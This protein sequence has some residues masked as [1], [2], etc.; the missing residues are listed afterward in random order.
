LAAFHDFLDELGIPRE[1]QLVR[2]IALEG[3][4]PE[5]VS[6]ARESLVPEITVTADGVYWHPVTATDERF[7]VTRI[8][9]PL[10]PALDTISRLFAEQWARTAEA[11]ALFP[12]A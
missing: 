2:P 7:L 8:I 3:A 4:A 1:D 11:A 10:T 9:E 5:G 6:L 12:C